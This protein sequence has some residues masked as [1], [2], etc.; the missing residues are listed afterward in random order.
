MERSKYLEL[1]QRASFKIDLSG[2]WWKVKWNREELV[3]WRESLYVPVDYRF[4]FRKGRALHTAILHDLQA[5]TEYMVLLS[6]VEY[7]IP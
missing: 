2:A 6:E 4:S 7:D 1:C 3:R 5:N